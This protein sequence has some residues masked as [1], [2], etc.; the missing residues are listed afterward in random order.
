MRFLRR[1]IPVNLFLTFLA[2]SLLSAQAQTFQ[3]GIGG[4]VADSSGATVPG[5]VVKATEDATGTSHDT[6]SSSAGDLQNFSNL[7]VEL[8]TSHLIRS[9]L[10]HRKIRQ[11]FVAARTST[12]L[13]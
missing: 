2:L 11:G 1:F 3:G 10:Q 9:G 13:R 5:A 12:T 6:I 8:M 4:S 7:P